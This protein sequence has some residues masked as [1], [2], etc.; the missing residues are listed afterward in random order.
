MKSVTDI[1]DLDLPVAK[2][3]V[4]ATAVDDRDKKMICL[5]IAMGEPEEAVARKLGFDKNTVNKVIRGND[6]IETII[7]LQTAAFPDPQARVKRMANVALDRMMKLLM[8]ST[9]DAT[10]AKV[11]GDIL[12]RSM[13]KA[14]QVVENRNLNVNV[15][16]MA[17]AD[18]ALKAQQERLERLEATQKKLLASRRAAIKG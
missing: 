10:V 3:V 2:N 13:G 6:G 14:T 9:S 17:S 12:D 18:R 15:T 5:L 1:F 7:R 4:P 8:H 11:A 16:D